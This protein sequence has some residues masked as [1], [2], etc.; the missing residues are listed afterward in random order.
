M[1]AW[2]LIF[3]VVA[4]VAGVLGFGGIAVAAAGIAKIIFFIAV[5]LFL[6]IFVLNILQGRKPPDPL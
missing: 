4:L 2:A 1:L 3:L 5:T 6:I